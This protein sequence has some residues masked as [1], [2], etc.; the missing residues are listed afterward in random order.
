[1][2]SLVGLFAGAVVFQLGALVAMN[3]ALPGVAVASP[4][5]ARLY[6]AGCKTN[7]SGTV[8]VCCNGQTV[9]Q[10]LQR[11]SSSGYKDGSAVPCGTSSSCTYTP[12]GSDKCGS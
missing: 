6:G 11:D 7:A 1:M 4:E 10:N 12:L 3:S 5:A 8:R 2:K 9:S